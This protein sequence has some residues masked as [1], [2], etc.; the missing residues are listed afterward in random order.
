MGTENNHADRKHAILSASSASRWLNCTPSAKMAEGL[1]EERSI[2][3]DEG[4]LAHEIC[5]NE[6]RYK[7]GLIDEPTYNGVLRTSKANPLY[8]TDMDE[9]IDYYVNFCLEQIAEARA[10]SADALV[11]VEEKV[12]L[13]VYIREG[14][15]TCD[16]IVIADGIM[17]VTDLKFGKGVRVSAVDNSQ[18]KLYA[19]GALEACGFLFDIHTVRLTIVQ[20]RLDAV[21]SWDVP[22]QDLLTWADTYVLPT[23]EKAFKGE[24]EHTPGDWCRFCKAK[25]F[26]PALRAEA[27]SA[28]QEDFSPDNSEEQIL[29]MYMKAGRIEAYLDAVGKYILKSALSGKKWTGLKVVRAN[30]NRT[31]KEPEKAIADLTKAKIDRALFINE[32]LMGLGDLK[33]YLGQERM[34][35]IV[36]KY[37]VKPEGGPT[38]APETDNRP[39]Y[40]GADDFK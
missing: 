28:A 23:A 38:L 27:M 11:L 26:C 30:T 22:A 4:T 35:K 18:L 40:S 8:S 33:K 21:S 12:S 3:A 25:V 2:H 17:Y 10:M 37:I 13:E 24:G 29:E 1:E 6:L 32:K 14:F 7:L 5:E 20:P 34:D 36:G 15:G 31:I 39:E 19:V 9:H 16:L